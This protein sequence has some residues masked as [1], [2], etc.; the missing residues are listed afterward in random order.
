MNCLEAL[1]KQVEDCAPC[2]MNAYIVSFR[3]LPEHEKFNFD[4]YEENKHFLL[5]CKKCDFYKLL[6]AT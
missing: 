2:R 3:D 4:Y 6:G 1:G 5:Y